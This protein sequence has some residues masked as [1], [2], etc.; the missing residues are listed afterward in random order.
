MELCE[1]SSLRVE[2]AQAGAAGEQT[3]LN[4]TRR[5]FCTEQRGYIDTEA[6]PQIYVPH[7]KS[8]VEICGAAVKS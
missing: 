2:C 8:P 7:R 5:P 6:N 1:A 4:L 3:A